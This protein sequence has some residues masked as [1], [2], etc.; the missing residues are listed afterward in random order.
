MIPRLLNVRSLLVVAVLV[1]PC[2]A[3]GSARDIPWQ[4]AWDEND[5]RPILEFFELEDVP[6]SGEVTV[7]FPFTAITEREGWDGKL[8]SMGCE[9]HVAATFEVGARG[10][11]HINSM[12]GLGRARERFAENFLRWLG[13]PLFRP[14]LPRQV[15]GD[16]VGFTHGD[17]SGVVL[18]PDGQVREIVM[19]RRNFVFSAAMVKGTPVLGNVESSPDDP[20]I[21]W[22]FD[23]MGELDKTILE[24]ET[25]KD[26]VPSDRVPTIT[27]L[28]HPDELVSRDGR[29]SF[30]V[31]FEAASP[32][33]HKILAYAL[34]D[35]RGTGASASVL[36]GAGDD[37]PRVRL[38]FTGNAAHP[39]T[40]ERQA[41]TLP[42]TYEFTFSAMDDHGLRGSTTIEVPVR[43]SE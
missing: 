16:E 7:G 14:P 36:K 40:E 42:E 30:E 39:M 25:A 17:R 9:T 18:S 21:Q 29:C 8:V 1:V 35:W 43:V 10:K 24:G 2:S 23:V 19:L 3:I 13:P 27:I 20:P 31:E 41:G 4:E 33:G 5:P 15:T 22:W 26:T 32:S 12:D 38:V 28:K 34:T 6:E 37:W 11:V